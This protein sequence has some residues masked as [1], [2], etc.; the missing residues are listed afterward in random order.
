MLLKYARWGLIS[1]LL[2]VG[3]LIVLQ[4]QRDYHSAPAIPSSAPEPPQSLTH[5]DQLAP[6]APDAGSLRADIPITPSSKDAPITVTTDVLNVQIDLLGGDLIYAALP[7]YEDRLNSG[8]PLQLLQRNN[9]HFYIAQSGLAG[10]DG[11]DNNTHNRPLYQAENDHYYLHSDTLDVVLRYAQNG[12]EIQKIFTFTRGSYA[13]GVRYVI[14]NQSDQAYETYFFA[15]LRHDGKRPEMS[16]G[17]IG[18]RPYFGAALVTE[19]SNY[20]KYDFADM[21]DADLDVVTT[22]GWIALVQH[23]FMS[24]WIPLNK[25][26]AHRYSTRLT[27]QRQ[28]VM[29]FTAPLISVAPGLREETGGILYIGPKIQKYLEPLARNLALTIDYGWLWFISQPLYHLLSWF[30]GFVHNWGVAIMLLTL[31]IKL[32]FFPLTQISFVSMA[33]MR[34]FAP[35]LQRIRERYQNDRQKIS[36]E[37]MKLYRKE[38]INPMSGCLPI[39]IQMPVF[40]ALYWTLIESVELRHAPFVLWITDLSA[41]DPYFV[42]PILMGLSMYAQQRLS[43]VMMDPMQAKIMRMLP[44]IFTIFLLWFPSGL[45][46]YWVINNLLSIAQQ[47]IINKRIESSGMSHRSRQ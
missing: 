46:L 44:I 11:I 19:E 38:K 47:Y 33:R 20:F 12:L 14:N 37:V 15:Q 17:G 43:P 23:Y 36:Q 30:Q 16:S 25:T 7:T 22:D 4:W 5:L 8:Q 39:I 35:H 21:T 40:I 26:V 29:G 28:Y 6:S 34:H 32:I 24:A 10:K 42:L 45:I 3:Y 1:A 13:I 31:T 41:M 18:I 9:R 2:L 27:P